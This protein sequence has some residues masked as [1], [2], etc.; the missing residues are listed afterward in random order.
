MMP[1]SIPPRASSHEVVATVTLFC[2]AALGC[3]ASSNASASDSRTDAGELPDTAASAVEAGPLL[4]DAARRGSVGDGDA[5]VD[6]G[7]HDAGGAPEGSALDAPSGSDA[8]MTTLMAVGLNGAPGWNAAELDIK[9][10]VNYVRLED[11]ATVSYETSIGLKVDVLS[12]LGGYNTS[13]VSGID[14]T[15]AAQTLVAWWKANCTVATCPVLEI[16]NEPS[17]S[18]FWGADASSSTNAAA[19]GNLVK[20]VYDTFVTAGGERPLL[21]GS[22]EPADGWGSVW[23]PANGMYVDGIVEHPYGGTGSASSSALGNRAQVSTAATA[24]GKPVYVT[25]V[26]WPTAV[27]QPPTGDSLQW[28]LADQ[29]TNMTNFITWAEGTGYVRSV[30]IFGYRD[31]GT[32]NWYGVETSGGAQKPS[33][34]ALKALATP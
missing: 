24:T 28:S 19:Y 30:M 4:R 11:P 3:S 16:L 7:T 18:W 12:E 20:V 5:G 1:T 15:S 26:G 33:Y 25:E 14:A 21:L 23:F 13:G 34:A 29:A 32:N 31:Y 9:N 27:G 10:C 2:V 6:A 22:Y 17:G 8:P